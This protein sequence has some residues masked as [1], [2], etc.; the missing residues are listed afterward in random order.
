MSTTKKGPV[1]K[2]GRLTKEGARWYRSCAP[3]VK[4][5][6][7]A[8]GVD[9]TQI[10]RELSRERRSPLAAAEAEVVRLAGSPKTSP[11]PFLGWLHQLAAEGAMDRP[12]RCVL[13]E[14]DR[15]CEVESRSQAG[16]D[17][18]QLRFRSSRSKDDLA[19]LSEAVAEHFAAAL[20]L[21][22]WLPRVQ[23]HLAARGSR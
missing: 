13:E 16:A 19:A 21:V 5:L 10:T 23:E 14:H 18:A 9:P 7:Y 11:A 3:A 2:A 15:R 1:G 4:N 8:R 6:A 22:L 17:L 12:V 20:D